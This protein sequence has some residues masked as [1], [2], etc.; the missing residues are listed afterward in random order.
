MYGVHPLQAVVPAVLQL[1][2]TRVVVD[3]ALVDVLK[4]SDVDD[5]AA[6]LREWPSAY[7]EV[8]LTE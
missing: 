5:G 1:V 8:E 7:L 3:Y 2:F 6:D 4:V